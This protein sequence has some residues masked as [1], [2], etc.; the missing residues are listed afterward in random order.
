MNNIAKC[1][2]N[3]KD[4]RTR[5]HKVERGSY[6]STYTYDGF[7][8]IEFCHTLNLLVFHRPIIQKGII[9]TERSL[10]YE[11][12]TRFGWDSG[13]VAVKNLLNKT[14]AFRQKDLVYTL[15]NRRFG[16]GTDQQPRPC[17]EAGQSA[18]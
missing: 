18:S 13:F 16:T 2:L 3:N 9:W 4:Y 12:S 10:I 8:M 6:V 17:S 11:I 15:I 1:I 14:L 5:K 7:K